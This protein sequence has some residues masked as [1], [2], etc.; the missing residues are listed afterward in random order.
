MK[1][2]EEEEHVSFHQPSIETGCL[3]LSV[4]LLITL[5]FPGSLSPSSCM[6]LFSVPSSVFHKKRPPPRLSVV[7]SPHSPLSPCR[8]VKHL[9]PSISP[10]H[11]LIPCV[12][13]PSFYPTQNTFWHILLVN[14]EC[15]GHQ[16]MMHWAIIMV[17]FRPMW[18]IP[19]A[20]WL[21][22][23]PTLHYSDWQTPWEQQRCTQAR[24]CSKMLKGIECF[25]SNVLIGG[26]KDL[27][28]KL[29]LSYCDF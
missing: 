3:S 16:F 27:L 10:P 8:E 11:F 5:S 25:Q 14:Q 9:S 1:P 19:S 29:N 22:L 26:V 17:Y 28:A 18:K 13:V 20:V 7:C 15:I 23:P 12:G 2:K 24:R 4:P 21:L 6:P